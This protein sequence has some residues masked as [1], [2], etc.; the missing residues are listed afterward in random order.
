MLN[1][2]IFGAPGA[3]KG[4]QA[5]QIAVRYNLI[6]LST[7][8]LFRA[9][10]AKG[11]EIG[12]KVKSYIDAGGL[13]PDELTIEVFSKRLE[14]GHNSAGFILDGFPRTLKQAESLDRIFSKQEL[15]LHGALF[16]EV[17]EKELIDRL[18]LRGKASGRSDD[19]EEVIKQRLAVYEEQ[20]APLV[21]YYKKHDKFSAIDGVGDIN[22]IF[23]NLCQEIDSL[24]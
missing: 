8:D 6:H 3:G 7:G 14:S 4:T 16:L 21:E 5:S 24:K 11:S 1:L 2:I 10:I 13:A 12:L 22:H 23:D 20:T 19:N 18:L 17:P 15:T 9:E